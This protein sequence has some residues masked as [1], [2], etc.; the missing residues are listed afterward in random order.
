MEIIAHRGASYDAPENTL[1]SVMLAWRQDVNVEIDIHLAADNRLVVIHDK[2]TER[3][4]GRKRIV[5]RTTSDDLRALDVG[6]FKSEDFAGEKTPLLE[7][8][9][10]TIPPGRKLYVEIKSG[11]ETVPV[12]EQAIQRSGKQSQI[13]IVGFDLDTVALAKE[14]MPGIPVYWLKGTE[15]EKVSGR[16]IPHDASLIQSAREKG[17]DGLD[18]HFAGVTE[19]FARAV[20]AAGLGL[21]IWTVDDPAEAS[22]LAALNVDGITTNRPAW[23]RDQ[24]AAPQAPKRDPGRKNRNPL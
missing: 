16:Y 12:L 17:L 8:V 2:D 21:Y 23:L 15:K 5:G 18:V 13:V 4:A 20:R 6:R 1:A 9:L 11:P 24:L 19:E 3:T 7:E 22:R 14:R 10:D